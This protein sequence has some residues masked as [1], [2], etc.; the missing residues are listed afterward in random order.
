M[1]FVRIIKIIIEGCRLKKRCP[2]LRDVRRGHKK[3]S[4][5][6]RGQRKGEKKKGIK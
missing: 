6:D 1:S 5:A 2:K 4:L 3:P